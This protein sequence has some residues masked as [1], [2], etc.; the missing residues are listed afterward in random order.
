MSVSSISFPIREFLSKKSVLL[1]AGPVTT[2][3]KLSSF[4]GAFSLINSATV[5]VTKD[6]INLNTGASKKE[7]SLF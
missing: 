3:S 4:R 1:K 7:I 2:A 5:G 6:L